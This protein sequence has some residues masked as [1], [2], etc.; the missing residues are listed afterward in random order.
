MAS[1]GSENE[2]GESF[3]AAG[4]E[5]RCGEAFPVRSVLSFCFCEVDERWEK[6]DGSSIWFSLLNCYFWALGSRQGSVK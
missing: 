2:C 6:E 5:I 3:A 1:G 4:D